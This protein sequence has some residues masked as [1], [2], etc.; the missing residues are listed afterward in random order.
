MT[1]PAI[2]TALTGTHTLHPSHSRIGLV[3]HHAMITKVHGSFEGLDRSGCFDV[4]DPAESQLR[5]TI[6]AAS[7]DAPVTSTAMHTC[8]PSA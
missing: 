5:L 2:P 3:A 8:A 7:V 4:E 6:K 1:T